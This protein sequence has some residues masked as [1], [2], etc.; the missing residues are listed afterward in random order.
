[1]DLG[2]LKSALVLQSLKPKVMYKIYYMLNGTKKYYHFGNCIGFKTEKEAQKR[3]SSMIPSRRRKALI[4][5]TEE[6]E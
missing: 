3:L 2:G 5:Y 1:M 4:E 6:E